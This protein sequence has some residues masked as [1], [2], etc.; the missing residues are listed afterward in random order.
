MSINKAEMA[1]LFKVLSDE[2]RLTILE[3]VSCHEMC[4]CELLERLEITQPTL[5]YH[6]KHLKEAGLVECRKD[7]NQH[8]YIIN[9]GKVELMKSVLTELTLDNPDCICKQ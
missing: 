9:R 5:S 4:G 8:F 2:Q 1:A 7:G 6:M 3:M